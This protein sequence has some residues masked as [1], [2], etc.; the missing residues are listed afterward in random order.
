MQ[1]NAGEISEKDIVDVLYNDRH[2]HTFDS[3]A[4]ASGRARGAHFSEADG[5]REC[6][7]QQKQL[8]MVRPR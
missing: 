6:Q 4:N 8:K 5:A 2:A 1:V 3:V 7:V